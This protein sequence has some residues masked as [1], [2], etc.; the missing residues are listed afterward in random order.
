MSCC[1]C[2]W[3]NPSVIEYEIFEE[4]MMIGI[5]PQRGTKQSSGMDVFIPNGFVKRFHNITNPMRFILKPN[6]DILIPLNLRVKIPEGFD[7]EVKNKSGI[8]TK[9]K[10]IKGAELIDQDYR[11]NIMIHLFNNGFSDV[12]LTDGM[13]I[14]QLVV[15]PVIIS[16]WKRVESID[17]NT[18][19]G[20]GRFGSTDR[21]E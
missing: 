5:E 19:R 14:S 18:E 9:L 7:I 21:K 11:G 10:L 4:D 1:D 17:T 16:E 3:K 20:E 6:F 13:K 12:E 8:S 15:R 2:P